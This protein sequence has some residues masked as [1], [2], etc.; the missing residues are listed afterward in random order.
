MRNESVAI[1][2]IRSGEICFSLGAK[3][4]N[5][6]FV[7]NDSNTRSYEGYCVE[8]FL[9]EASF[10]RAVSSAITSVRQH[11]EGVID[12]VYVGVP[13]PFISVLTRGH[14]ILF[15]SKRK[16]SA[17]DVDALFESGLNE[18][19]ANGRCIRRSAMYLTLGDNRKYFLPEELYGVSSNLLKGALCYYFLSEAFYETV[20]PLLEDLGFTSVQFVPSTLAQSVYLISE[21]QREGYAFLL[22]IGFL[23]SSISVVY[24]NGIV[25]EES[26]N[27]GVGT[28]LVAL[29]EG[30]G[31]EYYIAEEIL[32]SANISGGIVPKGMF[33]TTEQ[34]N[35][36]IPVQEIN[37]IIKCSLDVL[38]ERVDDF[39]AKRY[40]DKVT[41]VLMVN[42]INITG[43]G[44]SCIKG[45]AEHISKRLNRWTQIVF[46]DLPY[47][48][49]PMFS[50]RIGLLN[51][52]TGKMKKRSWI[53][54]IF[55]G[56]KK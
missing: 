6:T 10:R 17:Q 42:P 12:T 49:K 56:K 1:L 54:R 15:P 37:D 27:C 24:G 33:W 32:A 48:D 51:A 20:Y 14:T 2:D 31:V 45:A 50:S 21:K 23:T 29:M 7:F 3:G 18:L 13:S 52:A 47:Y 4:V 43:E 26:F 16:I 5:D 34:D 53:Q 55:G 8:G 40:K 46:P 30:L 39:F 38:C 9:D 44:I 25:H 19:M 36:Q 11:Y 22:D 28:I 41:S 35:C